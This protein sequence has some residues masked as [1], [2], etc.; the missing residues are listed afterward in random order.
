MA[1]GAHLGIALNVFHRQ[2]LRCGVFLAEIGVGKT[3][4]GA[5][6]MQ[7]WRM[8][9][10]GLLAGG[11]LVAAT[12]AAVAQAPGISQR[13]CQTIRTCNYARGGLYRGCLSSYTCRVC[14]FVRSSCFVDGSRRLCQQLRCTWG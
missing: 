3:A 2:A 9:V 13:D 4:S 8:S 5:V 1:A 10:I 7:N 12:A 11:F 6:A 14:R